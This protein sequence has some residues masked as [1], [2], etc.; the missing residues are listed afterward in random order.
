ML[1]WNTVI[2]RNLNAYNYSYKRSLVKQLDLRYK[3]GIL[4]YQLKVH[5]FI[6]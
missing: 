2:I 1:V 6:W 4:N 3:L 5:E